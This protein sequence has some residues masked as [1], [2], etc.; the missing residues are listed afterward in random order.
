[1]ST[2]D[3]RRLVHDAE[4]LNTAVWPVRADGLVTPVDQ[5]FTRSHAPIPRIDP[6]EWRL[7]VDGLVDRPRCFSLEELRGTFPRRSVTATLVCAGLRRDEF[8]SL[9]PLPSELPWG[10]EPVSTGE[11]TGIALERPAPGGGSRRAG[12]A[13]RSSPASMRWSARA[14][15][16]GSA[17]RSISPRR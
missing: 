5:F 2:T 11:W 15:G 9:G 1:M 16:S 17:D 14:T 7:E 3:G 4:G 13:R 10:P 6:T 12:P 8:L